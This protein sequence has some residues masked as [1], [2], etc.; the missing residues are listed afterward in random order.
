MAPVHEIRERESCKER[1]RPDEASIAASEEASIPRGTLIV[2]LVV[3]VGL[4]VNMD[5]A[6]IIDVVVDK[7]AFLAGG[8]FEA[9]AQQQRHIGRDCQTLLRGPLCSRVGNVAFN[10]D[11]SQIAHH[12]SPSLKSIAP[13]SDSCEPNRQRGLN[14]GGDIAP[15]PA[16][17]PER[18]AASEAFWRQWRAVGQRASIEGGYVALWRKLA[19]HGR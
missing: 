15:R 2:A 7:N 12:S 18:Q 5:F 11:P 10:F 4:A 8:S 16:A 6:T 9:S 13:S 17:L 19:R 14:E 1:S 3:F